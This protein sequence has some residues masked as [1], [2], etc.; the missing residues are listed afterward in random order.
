MQNQVVK[1]KILY[2]SLNAIK[3]RAKKNMLVSKTEVRK[4]KNN[5]ASFIDR[6][7]M[8][9]TTATKEHFKLVSHSL[10]KMTMTV[11]EKVKRDTNSRKQV[12]E[13]HL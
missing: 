7:S 3:N 5:V 10:K 9:S 12:K 11:L 8:L 4:K 2:N 1:P 6:K 13:K